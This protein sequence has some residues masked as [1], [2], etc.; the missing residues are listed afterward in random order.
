MTKGPAYAIVGRG[1]WAG[2]MH[3]V[4]AAEGRRI[5]GIEETRRRA[6]ESDV[7]YQLRLAAALAASGAQIAWLCVPPGA[8][9]RW[10]IQAALEAG[11]H[12]VVEKPWPCSRMES[13]ALRALARERKLLAAI[14]YEYCLLEEV[15]TWRRE[16]NQGVGLRWNGHF[17]Q[18]EHNRLGIPALENLGSHLLALR[19]YA[20][21]QSRIADIRCGYELPEERRVWVEKQDWSVAAID[22]L[23]N[24]EPI[25][26][27]FIARVETAAEGAEFPWGLDFA[28][29]VAEDVTAVRAKGRGAESA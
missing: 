22:F 8:H 24:C 11:L 23:G 29:R 1:R 17:T 9:T 13:E 14:H 2:R 26:Q 12:T 16:F 15:E 6:E 5:I 7:N 20:T 4:L 18:S 3:G 27:R 10:L 21:P 25:I 28:M 19:A